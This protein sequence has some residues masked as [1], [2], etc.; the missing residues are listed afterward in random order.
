MVLLAG[1]N[2]VYAG[3]LKDNVQEALY[4]IADRQFPDFKG[5]ADYAHWGQ[6]LSKAVQGNPDA[7]SA[8]GYTG[9]VN[10]Q[11]VAAEILRFMG[12]SAKLGK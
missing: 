7:L 3:S 8:I 4:S 1:G 2:K 5:K 9:E 10:K 6:A 11:A 12:N